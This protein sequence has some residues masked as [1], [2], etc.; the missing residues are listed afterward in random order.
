NHQPTLPLTEG[1]VTGEMPIAAL[2]S[3]A[4]VLRPLA[5]PRQAARN[6]ATPRAMLH[7]FGAFVALGGICHKA[8]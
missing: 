5:P 1:R 4:D 8:A 2:A 3:Q 7:R 6:S